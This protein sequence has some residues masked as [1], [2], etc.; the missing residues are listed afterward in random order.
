MTEACIISLCAKAN[1]SNFSFFTAAITAICLCIAI[2][3]NTNISW[4]AID[5]TKRD[6]EFVLMRWL[7]VNI[8]PIAD[9]VINSF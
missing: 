9:G 1:S 8:G 3:I 2:L 5:H 7:S 6:S 4:C